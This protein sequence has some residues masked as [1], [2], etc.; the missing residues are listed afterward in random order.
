[1]CWS[2]EF[3]FADLTITEL[4][5]STFWTNLFEFS[6]VKAHGA[7]F[8]SSPESPSGNPDVYGISSALS[9]A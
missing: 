7:Q 6:T 9:A 1:V 4:I 3:A 8:S 2:S 5:T